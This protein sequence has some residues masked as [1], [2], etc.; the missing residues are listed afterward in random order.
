MDGQRLIQRTTA[1]KQSVS[2]HG[3]VWFW[4]LVGLSLTDS[5]FSNFVDGKL[6]KII[7][8]LEDGQEPLLKGPETVIA[9]PNGELL[10]FARGGRLV[11]LDDFQPTEDPQTKTA[12]VTLAAGK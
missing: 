5:N 6:T 10:A 3:I 2:P 4:N 12:K 9:G 8:R 1:C 7:E 11:R